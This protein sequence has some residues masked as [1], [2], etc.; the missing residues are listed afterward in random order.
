MKTAFWPPKT[1]NSPYRQVNETWHSRMRISRVGHRNSNT[2]AKFEPSISSTTL[3][4]IDFLIKMLQLG[5]PLGGTSLILLRLN[6][7]H[8]NYFS[9]IYNRWNFGVDWSCSFWDLRGARKIII[10]IIITRGA[11]V[12]NDKVFVCTIVESLCIFELN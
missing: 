12:H 11:Q 5:A 1:E 2:H 6:Y 8:S 10:I 4:I 3:V 9:G 7:A